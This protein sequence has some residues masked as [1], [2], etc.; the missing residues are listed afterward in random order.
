MK[1]LKEL[2]KENKSSQPIK[3]KNAQGVIVI[4]EGLRPSDDEGGCM[5]TGTP[6]TVFGTSED[7]KSHWWNHPNN[8]TSDKPE[9]T[10]V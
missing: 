7:K 9:W 2:W 8:V 3:V 6:E 5:A 4:I 10:K 1:T